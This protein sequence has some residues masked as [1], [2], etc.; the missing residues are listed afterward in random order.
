SRSTFTPQGLF[1]GSG[2]NIY[3]F[4]NN[5]AL[6]TD[7]PRALQFNRNAL[8]FISVPVERKLYTTLAHYDFNDKV[9]AFFEGSYSDVLSDT[10][11]EPSAITNADAI[12]P[13]GNASRGL[14]VADN[15]FIPAVIRNDLAS[16]GEDTVLF[17]K[18]LN[19]V[20]D[21]SN[22]DHRFFYRVVG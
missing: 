19:G 12:G 14:S 22:F 8:R 6:V 13:D 4:D 11:L 9:T 16:A 2:D 20:F 1:F 15:P 17:R 10:S 5:N 3:T 21:R 18:R 7:Q